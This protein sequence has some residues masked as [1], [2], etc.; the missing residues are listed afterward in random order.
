MW[1][2]ASMLVNFSK[3]VAVFLLF[4]ACNVNTITPHT[5]SYSF[6]DLFAMGNC[7]P[8]GIPNYS[9]IR[10]IHCSDSPISSIAFLSPDELLSVNSEGQI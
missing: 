3:I 5:V 2:D 10:M 7:F 4:T 6:R 9:A 8:D 1:G